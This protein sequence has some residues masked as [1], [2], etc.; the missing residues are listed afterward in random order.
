MHR[1]SYQFW[2]R[3]WKM[4]EEVRGAADKS[5]QLLKENPWHPSLQFK[6]I[7]A[8]WSA[9]VGIAHRSL[10]V[11]DGNDYIWVWIG[12]HDDYENIIKKR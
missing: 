6:K 5:F 11:E 1:T 10:A 3:Y 2:H 7:G 12:N 8:F 4:P 9:R